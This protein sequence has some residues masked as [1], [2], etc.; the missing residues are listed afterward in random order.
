MTSTDDVQAYLVD[1]KYRWIARIDQEWES[2]T[3]RLRVSF[4]PTNSE[5]REMTLRTSLLA[6]TSLLSNPPPHRSIL[7]SRTIFFAA[8]LG[9]GN[10]WATTARSIHLSGPAYLCP[11]LS[12]LLFLTNVN[13]KIANRTASLNR[14][15]LCKTQAMCRS[16]GY[17][18]LIR[19]VYHGECR[20][21]IWQTL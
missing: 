14:W 1:K 4:P 17:G 2:L 6:N 20:P 19:T 7:G 9:H 8:H 16:P 3:E 13:F 18:W 11:R 21:V 12:G 10:T 5:A 15:S